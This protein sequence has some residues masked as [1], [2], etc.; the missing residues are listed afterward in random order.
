MASI[1]N[2]LLGTETRFIDTGKYR[3][4][5]ISAPAQNTEHP[6]DH[7]FMLHG[8]GGHAETYSRNLMAL[9]K[10]CQPH[11]IDFIWHGMSSK[12][13]YSNTGPQAKDHWLAQF[14]DQLLNLMDHM[15]IEKAA[16]EG[17]S[18]GGWIAFDMAVNHPDRT[19]K[20]ILNTAWGMH[21]DPAHVHEGASDLEA[22]RTTSVNALMNPTKELLRKRLDWLMPLG[23]VT[24][25]LVDLRLALWSIPETRTALVEYYERLFAPNIA[26]FYFQEEQIRTIKCPTLVLW[27][28]KNPIHGTDA[29]ERLRDIIPGAQMHVMAGCAHWPQWERPEEHDSVVGAFMRG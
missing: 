8:G 15:G 12:P 3:T 7:L 6:G 17:E 11:A 20:I 10:H 25:E 1:H 24:D 2:D 23:G 19:S 5:I 28:D 21:L 22:L 29:A 27:S 4:R 16:V 26:E 18:L 13:V 14:T 9:S